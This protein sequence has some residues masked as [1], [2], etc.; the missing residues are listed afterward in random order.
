MSRLRLLAVIA[1]MAVVAAGCTD[2]GGG[3]GDESTSSGEEVTL[4]FWVF[5]EG[6]IGS[7]LETLESDFEAAN[8]NVDVNITAY[9]EENYGVKLDTAIAQSLRWYMGILF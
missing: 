1:I 5:E 7:F 9:P 3:T 4:D 8:P 6:G 2:D